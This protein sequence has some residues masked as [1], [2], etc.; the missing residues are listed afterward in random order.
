MKKSLL[1]IVG[2]IISVILFQAFT[3]THQ[4][5]F[6]NLQILPKDIAD[7]DLDSIMHHFSASL[8]V[9][10]NFCHV[11]DTVAK[12]LDAANDAKPEKNIARKM[13]LMAIDIN[14]NYFRNMEQGDMDHD[15]DMNNNIA[16]DSAKISNPPMDTSMVMEPSK[17]MLRS[18]TCYTCH[19]GD[20]HPESKTPPR[21][22]GPPMAPP[23]TADKK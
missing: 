10:C 4:P 2:C 17:Y 22:E 12:K 20:P 6:K 9:R 3:T 14:K 18:V 1:I 11:V 23:K 21:K 16:H 15:H 7:H 5:H 8:G 19:R 13:M